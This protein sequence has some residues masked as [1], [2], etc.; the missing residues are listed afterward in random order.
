LYEL[1]SIHEA[2]LVLKRAVAYNNHDLRSWINLLEIF[3][4]DRSLGSP[5]QAIEMV[6]HLSGQTSL[7]ERY[8]SLRWTKI[9]WL[10]HRQDRMVM[11]CLRNTSDSESCETIVFGPSRYFDEMHLRS[12]QSFSNKKKQSSSTSSPNYP[13][14]PP[15]PPPVVLHIVQD[16][17]LVVGFI[18]GVIDGGPVPKL[19]SSLMRRFDKRKVTTVAYILSTTNTVKEAWIL[20]LLS[21]FNERVSLSDMDYRDSATIISRRGLHVLVD[22]NGYQL[23]SG[24]TL[25][26]LRPCGLQ[27][28]YLGDAVTSNLDYMDYYIGR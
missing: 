3:H 16:R 8:S 4:Y 27:I 15:P 14:T 25:M 28:N 9:E 12:Y 11:S 5:Q 7:N 17:R 22:V 26:R 24:V 1:G 13:R 2:G 21:S 20:E 6:E 19:L 23:L 10:E 18:F